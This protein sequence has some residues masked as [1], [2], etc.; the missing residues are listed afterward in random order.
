V[1]QYQD[2]DL[3]TLKNF[4]R[5]NM[6]LSIIL[7]AVWYSL[8]IVDA[9]V[10]AHLFEFDVSDNLSLRVEPVLEYQSRANNLTGLKVGLRF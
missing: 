7:T 5:R 8:N 3:K 10:D 2:D 4:Y 9:A 6:D 1:G